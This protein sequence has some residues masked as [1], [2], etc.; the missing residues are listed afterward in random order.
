MKHI[1]ID[2]YDEQ[3]REFIRTLPIEPEGV[4]LE[5]DGHIICKVIGPHQLSDEELDDV[6]KRGWGLVERAGDRNK[7]VP[8]KVIEHEVAEAVDEVRQ[9]RQHQ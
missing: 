8:A 4:E 3:V 9:R 5:L 6:L 1:S 7:G 2:Q